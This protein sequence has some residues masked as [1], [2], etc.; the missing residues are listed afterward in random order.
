ME[1]KSKL[2]VISCTNE[3]FLQTKLQYACFKMPSQLKHKAVKIEQKLF[4]LAVEA[5]K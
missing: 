1:F 5:C 3:H 2:H 4:W